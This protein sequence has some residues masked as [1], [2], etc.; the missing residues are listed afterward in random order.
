MTDYADCQTVINVENQSVLRVRAL[1]SSARYASVEIALISDIF[2]NMNLE[3]LL[4]NASILRY[5]RL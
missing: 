4:Y 3:F 1:P 5:V 2:G